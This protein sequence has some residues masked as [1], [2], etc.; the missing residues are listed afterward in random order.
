M[1]IDE[2]IA[3]SWADA[4]RKV[5][6]L[7]RPDAPA[8]EPPLA[9]DTA[10]DLAIVGGGFTGLWAAIQAKQD[11]PDRDVL[12]LERG[13]IAN[14]ASGRNG[15]FCDRSVTHGLANA[16]DRFPDEVD[17]ISELE[18]LSFRGL[19]AD[20]ERY[21]IE[22][23]LLRSGEM[24]VA[25][26]PHEL[27]AAHEE[28]DALRRLGEDVVVLDRD[29]VRAE[30]NSPR[31]VGGV[32]RRDAVVMLDPAR[33]AWGLKRAAGELGVRIHEGT[34]VT[35]LA[36][37]GPGVTIATSTGRVRARKAILATNA[38]PPLARQIRRYVVPV[39]DL[40]LMTE[41]L[42]QARRD[43]IGWRSRQG[44]GDMTNMFQYYRVTDDGRILWGG[45]DAIY[46]WRNGIDPSF[47]ERPETFDA[48]A[49]NF[50][51]TF[52][53]LEGLR[54]S[55]RWGGVI[56]TCSRFSVFFGT[57]LGGRVA[58]ALGYTGNGVGA[59]RFGAR[60][61]L[62]L[63]DGLDTGR[64]RLALVRGKPL[65]FPPEPLRWA[66]IQLTRHA[67]ARADRRQGKRGLWLR[68]LDTLGLGFAS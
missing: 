26:A 10:A 64:T 67:L 17:R 37:D 42:S 65:P 30:V 29:G 38:F 35:G 21:G 7:D 20:I 47:E 14:A 8:P 59:T 50:F 53:Q 31:F 40:V 49:R 16:M 56:D 55:H 22:C 48:L 54:F 57:S 60:T 33:L 11:D 25:R 66:G 19:L 62:D 43:A 28:T 32:W 68:L 52:P 15:G 12:L 2:Q 24:A 51:D 45:L 18:W 27:E 5:F 3:R 44:V 4:E 46:H 58:Y 13:S 1:P 6:W 36:V 63:V 23:D 34:E 9:A 41:P 61:A 39:Y